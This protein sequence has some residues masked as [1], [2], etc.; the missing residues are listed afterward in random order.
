MVSPINDIEIKESTLDEVIE[1]GPVQEYPRHGVSNTDETKAANG[2]VFSASPSALSIPL[3]S[4]SA[5]PNPS[6][7]AEANVDVLRQRRVLTFHGTFRR[8]S[9]F[10]PIL[11]NTVPQQTTRT[12]VVIKACSQ[13][14]ST[15]D[16]PPVL[17]KK[18]EGLGGFPGPLDLIHKIFKRAAPSTYHHLERKMTIPSATTLEGKKVPWL[19]FDGLVVG[20]NSD[21]RTDTLT[22]EQIEQI[23]GTEYRA[24]KML[25]WM[26]PVVGLLVPIYVSVKLISSLCSIS[27]VSS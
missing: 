4:P 26:V 20:R 17:N 9:C 6:I 1:K 12:F 22:T 25:S 18:D 21:F 19:N 23:G 10:L 13:G 15:T 14:D 7:A 2:A 27:L 11:T 3:P 24:L 5:S 16:V 8:L